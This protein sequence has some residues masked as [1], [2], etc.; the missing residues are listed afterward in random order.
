MLARGLGGRIAEEVIFGRDRVTT[1]ASNDLQKSAEIAR[2]M[3]VNQ[4]MG[5]KLRDQ[6]FHVDDG[7]MLDRLVHEREYSDE[8]AKVIDDEVESLI[9]EAAN[10]AREVIKANL[11]K[12]EALKDKLLEKETV[13]AD[14]VAELLKGS[15]LPQAAA[16]Y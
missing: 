3:V 4:G 8:T 6:V 16:L 1:G 5:K 15:K 12:L 2:D 10:R 13:D 7:M 9:T 14:E 11:D